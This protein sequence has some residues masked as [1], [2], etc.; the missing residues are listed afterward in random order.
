[1]A[2]KTSFSSHSSLSNRD[3]S[4]GVFRRFGPLTA[5][6]FFSITS[7]AQA[8]ESSPE[9]TAA[10]PEAPHFEEEASAEPTST[11]DPEG[12]PTESETEKA[13]TPA[14][15]GESQAPIGLVNDS[16]KN[17]LYLELFGP[18]LL[19]SFNYERRIQDFNL[20]IGFGGASWGGAGYFVVPFGATYTGI[21][22]RQHRFELGATGTFIFANN[23]FSRAST[24]AFQPII[25]YRRESRDGGF[26]FRAGLSPWIS[27]S[28][29]LPWGHVSFGFTF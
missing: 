8:E 2:T 7:A 20:R 15:E 9:A 12:K 29:V 23:S 24:F 1:M 3:I 5:L 21:G 16:A 10:Q 26:S 11:L 27:G 13:R 4:A 28:G 6:A 14:P 18:G 25:G 22:V 17:T 19:Y